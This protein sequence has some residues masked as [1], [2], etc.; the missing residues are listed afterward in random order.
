MPQ[1]DGACILYV[2]QG[3]PGRT[4]GKLQMLGSNLVGYGQGLIEIRYH[5]DGSPVLEGGTGNL[6]PRQ[7]FHLLVKLG[8]QGLGHHGLLDNTDGRCQG[9]VFCLA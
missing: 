4:D 5:N 1:E 9:I 8:C 3:I 2:R 7:L 6:C